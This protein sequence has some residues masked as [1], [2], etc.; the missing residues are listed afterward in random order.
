METVKA[1]ENEGGRSGFSK[2]WAALFLLVSVAAVP[3]SARA[4]VVDLTQ[5][6]SG[7]INGAQFVFTTQQPTGTGV[8][9]PFLREQVNG[10]GG[11]EQGYNTS[12][13][14][15]PFDDKVGPFTHDL[16]IGDLSHSIQTVNGVQ[17][18]TLLL[19]I[20]EP[21]SRSLVSLDQLNIYTSPTGSTTSTNLNDLGMLRY[22]LDAGMDSFVLLDAARNHGSG[23][24]DMLA[25]IPVA[26]FAGSKP[27]DYVYLYALFGQNHPQYGD[28]QAQG[29]FEEWSLV[30]N[31]APV[32]EM[33]ALFPI[34]GLCAAAYA[35]QHVRRR[36]ARQL[37]TVKKISVG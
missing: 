8:I 35:T 14:P 33:S 30:N 31:A 12:G 1:M 4:T 22:S 25:Y 17:Y 16:T 36:N 26:D 19:D 3:P 7:S 5:T 23:S 20:N 13:R 9:D 28:T 21:A 2:L 37:A 32:P 27:N 29:G 10:S 11:I 6:D 15:A 18:Y 24:G 34:I